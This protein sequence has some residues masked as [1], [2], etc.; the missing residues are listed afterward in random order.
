MNK[1]FDLKA[2]LKGEPVVDIAG[3]KIA[4][5]KL[6]VPL[7]RTGTA[8][9]TLLAQLLNSGEVVGYFD[10]NGRST[11]GNYTLF[12]APQEVTVWA[13][14]Y[15]IPQPQEAVLVN[16]YGDE[17]TADAYAEGKRRVNDAATP[18]KLSL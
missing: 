4:I 12:T 7:N 11:L 18:I 5:T 17:K 2:A 6:S 8:L 16:I 1:P 13:N 9:Q 10:D 15:T 14:V 3:R